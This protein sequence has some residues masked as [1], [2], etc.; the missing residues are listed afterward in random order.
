MRI[1][2]TKGLIPKVTSESSAEFAGFLIRIKT[3]VWLFVLY[4]F[5]HS[6]THFRFRVTA[7]DRP[8]EELDTHK[9]HNNSGNPPK[10]FIA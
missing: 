5:P 6:Y 7:E 10:N 9:P 3:S 4:T 1:L 8:G 2:T